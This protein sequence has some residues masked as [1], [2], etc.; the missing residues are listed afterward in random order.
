MARGGGL[1]R[2]V[3]H[4]LCRTQCRSGR[5]LLAHHGC[6]RTMTAPWAKRRKL[7][8]DDADMAGWRPAKEQKMVIPLNAYY[9]KLK[10]FLVTK[11]FPYL[12]TWVAFLGLLVSGVGCSSFNRDWKSAAFAVPP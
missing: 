4:T 6:S 7:I 3:T 2:N 10:K 11:L 5:F 12:T 1:N 8:G 9:P